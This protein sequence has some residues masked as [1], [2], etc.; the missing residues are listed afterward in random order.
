[1]KK[2]LLFLSF[3]FAFVF[4]KSQTLEWVNKLSGYSGSTSG[5]EEPVITVESQG[6]IYTTGQCDDS[7]DFDS[8]FGIVNPFAGSIVG[9]YNKYILKT[10]LLGNFIWVKQFPTDINGIDVDRNGNVFITGRTSPPSDLDP[11]IGVYTVTSS[12]TFVLKLNSNGDFLWAK[13]I[14]PLAYLGYGQCLKAD[15]NGNIIVMGRFNYSDDFDP[16]SGVYNLTCY[17]TPGCDLFILK[18]DS[19][20]NFLW[21]KGMSY[22]YDNADCRSILVDSMGNIY[23]AITSQGI[24]I[25]GTT[26]PSTNTCFIKQDSLGNYIWIK[27]I[28]G[29]W[30]YVNAMALDNSDNLY[31]IGDFQ[32]STAD[33]DP[34]SGIVNLPFA[35]GRDAFL[36]KLDSAG[37]FSWV[38]QFSSSGNEF[39]KKIAIDIANRIYVIGTF[40]GTF[41]AD[42]SAG[43]TNVTS[44][45]YMDVFMSK[46]NSN[47]NFIWTKS[48]GSATYS[49]EA[50]SIIVDSSFNIYTRSW[51]REGINF[52]SIYLF[53]SY[54]ANYIA[55]YSQDV[56]SNFEIIIDSVTN[57]KCA[58]SGFSLVHSINGSPPYNYLWNTIPAINDSIASFTTPGI[59]QLLVTDNYLCN[60][61][62]S[63]LVDGP[64]FISNFDL[65]AN[66][67]S[68]NY[69]TGR[70]SHIWLDAYN[71][72]CTATSGSLQL[73][74]DTLLNYSA[75]IPPPDIINGD[76]LVW[77]FNNLV[78][79]SIHIS[80]QITVQTPI[81][82]AIGDT[83]CFK[84]I[85][86]PI[87]GDVDTLNNIK[88]YCFPIIN[89][90][91]PNEKTVSPKGLCTQGYI[92]N[93]EELAYTIRFQNTGNASAINISVLDT[94]STN[95]N[96][97][98]VR[99]IGN[100]HALVTEVL[101]SNVLKFRFDNINLADSTSNESASHGYVIFE[102]MPN[103]SL[104]LGTTITNNAGIYFDFNPPIYTN[105]VL[106]TISNGLLNI[107]TTSIGNTATADLSGAV[108]Q[109]LDCNNGNAIILG[110]IGQSYT[111]TQN[112]NYS[113]IINDGC[114]IDTSSCVSLSVI[115]ISKLKNSN[116][117]SF[118]PNPS[119]N[120]IVINTL[121]STEIKIINMLG[122][123]I[124]E[125]PVQDKSVIDISS[126]ANGIY[127]I[128]TKEGFITKLIKQ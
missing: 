69:R 67:I 116:Q 60:R 82:A 89:G 15:S 37:I 70:L 93:N 111:A 34:G 53:S 122:E 63:I 2:T 9:G 86:N 104:A 105:L 59:Y 42:P 96:L 56:C 81:W 74:L 36:L 23:S 39:G 112:G 66:L 4:S 72:G 95:L 7:T 57:I 16:G 46:Y 77:S 21:V 102:V 78:Y 17:S 127:Y 92:N 115:G 50:H 125:N 100:S 119:E 11:G 85:I 121:Q 33:F 117:F 6:F 106:N 55:K 113:V 10:D 83:I 108:Y 98:T 118:Y 27:A 88:E 41:D 52:D 76:T 26:Y 103:A 62:T 109:W 91:D 126:L 110:A 3:V 20:G 38:K 32:G 54:G 120:T 30:P 90:Y 99:V 73:I 29:G 65:N 75:S 79:D 64:F 49:D 114:F 35:G 44:N 123:I 28:T 58:D 71:D 24:I 18:L 8:G 43:T 94:L 19:N 51:S 22:G 12:G 107:G 101:P 128:K 13:Q 25:N 87:S 47:G 97:N 124:I 80:P 31:A 14:A 61:S 48:L 5:L 40:D 68:T 84:V 1:M 45:G